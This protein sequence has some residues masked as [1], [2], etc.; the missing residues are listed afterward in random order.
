[1]IGGQAQFGL[2]RLVYP[3]AK[4]AAA[5]NGGA[6][7]PFISTRPLTVAACCAISRWI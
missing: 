2:D 1:L 3:K 7:A 6:Y 5:V 4:L